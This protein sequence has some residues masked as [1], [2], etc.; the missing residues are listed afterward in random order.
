MLGDEGDKGLV[1]DRGENGTKG[2]IGITGDIGNKGARGDMG[3]QGPN[4]TKGEKGFPGDTAIQGPKGG[5]GEKGDNGTQGQRGD[6]GPKGMTG[7]SGGTGDTGKEGCRGCSLAK[8]M[9]SPGQTVEGGS[10]YG[11]VIVSRPQIGTVGFVIGT[12]SLCIYTPLGWIDVE[13]G[14]SVVV[15]KR[16]AV[17]RN[18][19][20]VIPLTPDNVQKFRRHLVPLLPLL[21]SLGGKLLIPDPVCGNGMK[22]GGEECDGKDLGDATCPQHHGNMYIGSPQCSA[23]CRLDMSNCQPLSLIL[24]ALSSDVDGG[25][26]TTGDSGVLNLINGTSRA[27]IL[28]QKDAESYGLWGRYSA[29]ISTKQHNLQNITAE[30]YRHLPIVNTMGHI[31]ASKWEDLVKWRLRDAPLLTLEGDD[32][33]KGHRS[34]V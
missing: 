16:E 20:D 31:V 32:I 3:I 25:M 22:E 14:D 34:V 24:F 7:P 2:D 29:L 4:G 21:R 10:G 17:P 6:M 28:C 11:D 1:G 30:K 8:I 12:R 27:N 15:S 33:R 9:V 5:M 18:R 26:M 23:S 19:R 13:S